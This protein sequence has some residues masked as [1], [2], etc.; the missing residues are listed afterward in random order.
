MSNLSVSERRGVALVPNTSVD[1]YSVG[2]S[3]AGVAEIYMAR[4]NPNCRITATTID[5]EGCEATRELVAKEGLQERISIK[6]EDVTKPL[7]YSDNSFGYVYARL[8]LHYLTKQQLLSSLSELYRVMQGGA[9]L[10]I[11]VRSNRNKDCQPE[12]VISYDEYTG[13]TRHISHPNP[14]VSEERER[15][16][17]DEASISAFINV[18]GFAV[19]TVE[20]YD[21]RLFHDYHR[22]VYVDSDDNLI[23]V[24]ARKPEHPNKN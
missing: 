19:E 3:T 10:F 24:T 2:V 16:F 6:L 20:T 1:I 5:K 13:M 21:E 23:E 14:S 18:A 22:S 15:F 8:I 4:Q 7:P 9:L 12:N 17:Q 11:V